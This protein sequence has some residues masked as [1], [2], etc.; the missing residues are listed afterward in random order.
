[1]LPGFE[2]S[3]GR[4]TWLGTVEVTADEAVATKS[5]EEATERENASDWLLEF[6]A[7]PTPSAVVR[8]AARKAGIADRTLRRAARKAGVYIERHGWGGG[9]TWYPPGAFAGESPVAADSLPLPHSGQNLHSGQANKCGR[10]AGTWPEQA[11]ETSNERR[12]E[13]LDD[14][15]GVVL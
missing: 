10:D 15:R 4:V 13:P 12:K 8:D 3:V 6:L 11:T 5:H 2:R 7:A 9:A 1:M 14:G